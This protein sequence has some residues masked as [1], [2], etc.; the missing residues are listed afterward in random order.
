MQLKPCPRCDSENVAIIKET[1]VFDMT[2]DDFGG[3][4]IYSLVECKDCKFRG[5]MQSTEFSAESSW[6]DRTEV[7]DRVVSKSKKIL[8]ITKR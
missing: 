4:D 1:E 8:V 2:L 3:E 5:R 6:S 7:G